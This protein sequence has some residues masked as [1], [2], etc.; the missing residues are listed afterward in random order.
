MA[1]CPESNEPSFGSK[2]RETEALSCLLPR[3]S[4]L[5]F[6]P[7]SCVSSLSWLTLEVPRNTRKH[8]K[9]A[10][11]ARNAKRGRFP[12]NLRSLQ[13]I[14]AISRARG[15]QNLKFEISN[16]KSQR[17][18]TPWAIS[19]SRWTRQRQHAEFPLKLVKSAAPVLISLAPLSRHRNTPRQSPHRD[20]VP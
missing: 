7:F 8:T 11:E 14:C 10:S 3:F 12:E 1:R 19:R 5:S 16:L 15:F 2:R 20:S 9:R 6:N 4:F 17:R 18:G 13:T